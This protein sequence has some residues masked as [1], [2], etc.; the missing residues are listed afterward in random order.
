MMCLGGAPTREVGVRRM[1]G[2][3]GCFSAEESGVVLLLR[4]RM[5][6][7]RCMAGEAI[8][9]RNWDIREGKKGANSGMDKAWL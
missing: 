6:G 7:E 4:R 1:G 2:S 8:S 3:W 9:L 5:E